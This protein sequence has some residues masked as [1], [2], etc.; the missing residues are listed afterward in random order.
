MI[1]ISEIPFGSTSDFLHHF[2][3]SGEVTGALGWRVGLKFH[4]AVAEM[5]S[6]IPTIGDWG[7]TEHEFSLSRWVVENH[8]KESHEL[9]LQH[10]VDV[11]LC[12]AAR[13]GNN[14]ESY[15]KFEF[16]DGYF[17]YY[18]INLKTFSHHC[19]AT[20]RGLTL[21]EFLGWVADRWG[22]ETHLRVA[23]R[24]LRGNGQST[25]KVLPTE[26]GLQVANDIP[27]PVYT[28]PRFRQ[29]LRMLRD[30]GTVEAT[31][32]D[33]YRLTGLGRELLESIIGN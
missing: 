30:L 23:L 27:S 21:K 24:K 15:A 20:W 29:G 28:S 18:P 4:D 11:L 33:R 7:N 10:S 13:E 22:L 16:P 8:A 9:T 17:T 32:E 3:T 14:A 25:F 19:G 5:K 31:G 26:N 12:L 6:R 2:L 1:R